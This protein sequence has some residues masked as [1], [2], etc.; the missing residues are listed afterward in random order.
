MHEASVF[1]L[2]DPPLQEALVG[3]RLEARFQLTEPHLSL[4]EQEGAPG[5]VAT[6][7]KDGEKRQEEDIEEQVL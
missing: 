5:S 7:Q 4:A 3:E 6:V 2:G 1:F